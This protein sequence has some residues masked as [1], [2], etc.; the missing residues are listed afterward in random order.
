MRHLSQIAP[1]HCLMTLFQRRSLSF[2]PQEFSRQVFVD[3]SVACCHSPGHRNN[4]DKY[5]IAFCSLQ[6]PVFTWLIAFCPHTAA[7]FPLISIGLQ[8]FCIFAPSWN[9]SHMP[10]EGLLYPRLFGIK[11]RFLINTLKD[12]LSRDATGWNSSEEILKFFA[13]FLSFYYALR[14]L[15]L[16]SDTSGES[17]R[18]DGSLSLS[19]SG[20]SSWLQKIVSSIIGLRLSALFALGSIW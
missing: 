12:S 6:N 8:Q 13:V 5:K 20:I 4:L 7:S 17:W 11:S 10:T 16:T 15:F 14:P 18:F 9:I 19:F 3:L 2:G 1:E